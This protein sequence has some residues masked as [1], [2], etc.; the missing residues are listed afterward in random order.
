[1]ANGVPVRALIMQDY[2]N[3]N[4]GKGL[5]TVEVWQTVSQRKALSRNLI[6]QTM[7]YFAALVST[8]ALLVWFGI[9]FGLRPCG[10]WRGQFSPER[11][12]ISNRS[13]VGC[14]L[15]SERLSRR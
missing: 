10:I 15:S 8:A 12:T 9:T 14:R 2:V 6:F 3:E 5:A 13:A 1:M 11:P 7:L 4:G